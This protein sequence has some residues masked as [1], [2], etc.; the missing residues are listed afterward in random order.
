MKMMLPASPDPAAAQLADRALHDIADN[1]AQA[2][3]HLE[4]AADARVAEV[5]ARHSASLAR[6]ARICKA[7]QERLFELEH[8][9]RTAD[10]RRTAEAG[11]FADQA[12]KR[13]AEFTASLTR[14]LQSRDTLAAELAAAT[15]AFDAVQ[16]ARRA[17]AAAAADLLRSREA[18]F[19][20][21]MA[22]AA[23]ARADLERA[24]SE[25]ET[26][27]RDERARAGIALT[28]AQERH[29]FLD[30]L[31]SQEADRRTQLEQKLASIEASV[32]DAEDRHTA[33]LAR[34]VA[35]QAEVQARYDASLAEHAAERAVLERQL[36]EAAATQDE[37]AARAAAALAEASAREADLDARLAVEAE[38]RAAV[39]RELASFRTATSQRE[40]RLVQLV[41]AHRRRT[42][43][44]RIAL[45]S[46]LAGARAEAA[47]ERD[48]KGALG[49]RL[50]VTQGSYDDLLR[51]TEQDR[52]TYE[53]DRASAAAELQ[54]VSGEYA[55]LR[56]SFDQLQSAFRTL[57]EI[58]SEHAAERARL[59]NVAAE[60]ERELNAQAQR[61]RLA[62]QAAQDA[63]AEAEG[64]LRQSL[65]ASHADVVR[66]QQER[67]TLRR[68]LE[69]ARAEADALRRDAERLPDLQ[70]Q[71]DLSQRERR[72]EFERAPH[73]LCLCT[74]AGVI[75]DANHS[76]V[77]M[78][79][80][81]RADDLRSMELTAAV[82]DSAG[83]LGW[84]LERARTMRRTEPVETTWKTRDG[85][86]LVVRLQAFLTTAGSVD[87]IADDI[88]RVRANEERLRQ[89]QR[90]EAVGRLASEV[91]VTCDAVLG[92][93]ARGLREW[94]TET[95]TAD[96]LRHGDRLLT[97]VTRAA[98]YLR[99]LR[100]Y[101]D[102]QM[103]ALEPVSVQRVLSD[104]APV[105]KRVVGEPITVVLS[106]S[107][108]SF[109]V[110]LEAERLER[111]LV[112]VA[113]YARERM[114]AG[115]Q[116]RID[117]AI[118]A[119]GRRF[120]SRYPNVRPGHHVLITITELPRAGKP[121]E[122]IDRD[123]RD[124]DRPGVELTTLVDLVA[125]CGG[126][127][128]LEAQRAGNLVMKIYL[129]RRAA[130]EGADSG[131]PGG[132]APRGGRLARW[133]RGAP[134]VKIR[135]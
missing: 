126:H 118:T 95:G 26:A 27:L 6:E 38:T 20:A 37:A 133:F 77:A 50:A 117:L 100:V 123:I 24:L 19:E 83:D 128:W 82:F 33:E 124:S 40:H 14:T 28:A 88:T 127:L 89:A 119:L 64:S 114:A 80:F 101:G 16:Q 7:L 87:I 63:F 17:D 57:D 94:A 66:L 107:S 12:A 105:L 91:S 9:L 104:L 111:V 44:Q 25:A 122:T 68:E 74:P 45:R 29:A 99:Q 112:N 15:A 36:T 69:A 85:R 56:E 35:R 92:D 8:A 43:Q 134:P 34:A 2:L 49:Q 39:E 75:I 125:S 58:A 32:E 96:A 98:S 47:F 108:G 60:H 11:A 97:D 121:R 86:D 30:E 21:A 10:D 109:D 5:E 132:R 116:M 41:S 31:L 81:R 106:K 1:V 93:V 67:D 23:A 4:A 61:H 46:E 131:S 48:E 42:R 102:Q 62:E 22:D 3:N 59:E 103:R 90:I 135:A 113:S 70:T 55:Q 13:H 73:G 53:R 120:V 18:A 79:G 72:R 52:A 54:R 51:A 78:L 71:L 110:D 76:F 130:V 115:G 84:L 65:T 129:P